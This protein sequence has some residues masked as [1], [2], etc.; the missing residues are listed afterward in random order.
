MILVLGLAFA[1]GPALAIPAANCPMANEQMPTG[2][3]DMDCCAPACAPDCAIA[4]PAAVMPEPV[5]ASNPQLRSAD[6]SSW[7]PQAVPAT[8]LTSEDPPPRTTFS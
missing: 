4:C 5:A 3:A 8:D 7:V 1:S 6:L 2:H